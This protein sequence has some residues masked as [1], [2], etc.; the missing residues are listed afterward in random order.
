MR[1]MFSTRAE[2]DVK[3]TT[4][5]GEI[6]D[7]SMNGVFLIAQSDAAVGDPCDVRIYLGNEEPLLIH[8][9][10]EVARCDPDGLA[11]RFT[12]LYCESFPHLKQVVLSNSEQ[13]ERVEQE[14]GEHLGIMPEQ[15]ERSES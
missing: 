9:L 8:A 13:S 14:L 5:R 1:V 4:L 15:I 2:V 11:V 3:G 10:G 7:V 6:R 12:G